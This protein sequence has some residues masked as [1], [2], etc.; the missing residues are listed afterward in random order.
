MLLTTQ[1][2][3]KLDLGAPMCPYYTAFGFE[4]VTWSKKA[5]PRSASMQW[6]HSG[7]WWYPAVLQAH[8]KSRVCLF[9][10]I[11][12]GKSRDGAS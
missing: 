1:S 12:Q 4:A 7:S 8:V 5:S 9:V 2:S 10:H 6:H 3:V 11:D